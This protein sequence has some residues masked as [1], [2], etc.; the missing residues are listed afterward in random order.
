MAP[1]V[2]LIPRFRRSPAALGN[3]LVCSDPVRERDDRMRVHG[4]YV[5]TACA[6]YRLRR[7]GRSRELGTRRRESFT[8]D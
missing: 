6:G 8:G 3:C 4:R 7:V 5:H 2:S 1:I